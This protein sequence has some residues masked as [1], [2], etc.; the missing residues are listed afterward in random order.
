MK[1]KIKDVLPI[2]EGLFPPSLADEGDN[3]GLQIGNGSKSLRAVAVGLEATPQ[4]VIAASS[5]KANLLLTH[6]PLIYRPLKRI[7]AAD[8]AGA[9]VLA[10]ARADVAV[11]SCH[12]NADWA[13]GGL[14]DHLAAVL[15]LKDVKPL[16]PRA[17]AI[18]FKVVTF[19]PEEALER[20]AEAMFREGAGIIGEY[21][22]CSFRLE[23]MGT[24]LPGDSANPYSGTVGKLSKEKET[25]LETLVK[26]SLLEKVIGALVAAHPYEEV[27]Y[28]VYPLA[29]AGSRHGVARIGLLP[30]PETAR[31][32]ARLIK[33]TVRP[34]FI[35]GIGPMDAPVESVVICA[36]SGGS[37]IGAAAA[38]PG[39][40]LVTG[41][42]GYHQARNAEQSGLP[43]LDIGHFGSEKCFISLA[44]EK[45]R[46][47]LDSAGISVPV[48]SL[49]TEKDPFQIL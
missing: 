18:L 11:F 6:H 47:A 32:I 46:Q 13:A 3:I 26:A 42:V 1:V 23:G 25:R 45:L 37:L 7:S 5:L 8:P 31:S 14:N 44:A 40:L 9:A 4:T 2:I 28:D 15:K 30:K 22:K 27:A 38:F 10:A 48:Y 19:V 43:V 21:G 17:D 24:F 20:V 39:T 16:V 12:T 36:G 49:D 29:S 33:K 41:D 35:R 34:T